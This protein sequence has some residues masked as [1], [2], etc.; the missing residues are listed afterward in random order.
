[1]SSDKPF[2]SSSKIIED[3][4]LL[5][6]YME[7]CRLTGAECEKLLPTSQILA[8]IK[9]LIESRVATFEDV[10]GFVEKEFYNEINCEICVDA[11]KE[12]YGISVDCDKARRALI[13]Q[14]TGWFIEILDT[15]GYVKI[16]Y[17]WK[18]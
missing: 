2:L 11:F 4:K 9:A 3:Y 14:I 18:P 13:V 15:L 10:L 17:S 12:V 1:M 5:L 7:K 6:K 16:K 8:K